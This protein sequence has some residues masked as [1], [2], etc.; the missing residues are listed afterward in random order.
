MS[1]PQSSSKAR[2]FILLLVLVF[3]LAIGLL[4]IRLLANFFSPAAPAPLSESTPSPPPALST[5]SA[6]MTQSPT[7]RAQ[8][9]TPTPTVSPTPD[10]FTFAVCGDSRGGDAIYLEIL[11]RVVADG[12]AFLLHTGDLVNVG[13]VHQFRHF[14]NLMADFPLPFYPTAGNHDAQGGSLEHYLAYS[15]AP[16]AHYSFDVGQ[17]HFAVIDS[18]HGSL[19]NTELEWLDADLAASDQPLKLVLL[20]HPPFDP[21]GTDH[22]MVGGNAAFMDV[23]ERQG[24]EIV[25]AG[26]IHAFVEGEQNGVRYIITGSGGAP[27]YA[28]GHPNAFYHYILVHVRGAE[29]ELEVVPVENPET[30][31]PSR[32]RRALIVS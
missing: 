14:A 31:L 13:G 15:G 6:S 30:R 28:G 29:I 4:E 5:A 19:P 21:D 12:A 1:H 25:F 10:E 18:H 11:R 2:R 16:A 32:D 3:T 9:A 27:L 23:V 8:A 17:A 24:V 7:S 26:H 22:I 20:H